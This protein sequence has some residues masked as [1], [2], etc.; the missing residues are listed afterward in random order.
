MLTLVPILQ[1]N[2]GIVVCDAG[3]GT[4]GLI[5][6]EIRQIDP[7]FLAETGAATSGVCGSGLVDRNFEALFVSRMKHHY[8]SLST[9]T[10][11]QVMKN[12]GTVKRS[13][14]DT[15][16][17]KYLYVNVPTVATIEEAGVYGGNFEISR[18]EL[19]ASLRLLAY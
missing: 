14:R 9:V 15:P 17:Q 13:F 7:L 8:N 16:G 18:Y 11:Q 4:V 6:C 10:R 3:G 5:S 1:V 2:D 19:S 12:F